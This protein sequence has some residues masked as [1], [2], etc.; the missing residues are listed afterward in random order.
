[1]GNTQVTNL[2][3]RIKK[4]IPVN[5]GFID[6][7]IEAVADVD[8]VTVVYGG[9]GTGK[10]AKPIIMIKEE[11][12]PK[13][14]QVVAFNNST[15]HWFEN[16][17][18]EEECV[19]VRTIDSI[20]VSFVGFENMVKVGDDIE[21]GVETLRRRVSSLFHVP[22]SNDP[23][24]LEEGNELFGLFDYVANK[25]GRDGIDTVIRVLSKVFPRYGAVL[26]VYIKCLE[27]KVRLRNSKKG[28]VF[29]CKPRYDFTL[30]RLEL[31]NSVLPRVKVGRE[32]CGAPRTLIV[33]EVQDLSPL[34]WA[35]LGKWLSSGEVEHFIVAGDF[36][37][38]IYRSLHHADLEIPRWLYH[39]AKVKHGWQ[40]IELT[41]SHRVPQPLDTL[42]I[43]FLNAFDKDPSPWRKWKG[44]R[45]KFG[46]LYIKPL[47]LALFEIARD[48]EQKEDLRWGRSSYAVLAPTNEVVL[49]VS[50][51][52]MTLGVLPHFLKGY[53]SAVA[54]YIEVVRRVVNGELGLG[55]LEALDD[56]SKN[57]IYGILRYVKLRARDYA[58]RSIVYHLS[59]EREVSDSDVMKYVVENEL[60][61][62][63]LVYAGNPNAPVFVD[64]VYTAKGLEFDRVYIAN[65]TLK[66]SRVPRD[67]WGARLFYVALT[68]SRGS[69]V[70]MTSNKEGDVEWFPVKAIAELAR[71][72]GVEVVVE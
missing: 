13:P 39:Q 1:M 7:F 58:V 12:V 34:M 32:D 53:P 29:D 41:H 21:R 70:I 48:V 25:A 35:I 16:R 23:Y 50:T 20:A 40:V 24:K 3:D 64:T 26:D 22:F 54:D 57:V 18:G 47:P 52:L 6:G 43:A 51:A 65:F 37:Q 69:V 72:A 56:D 66:N 62:K 4:L 42:A 33:D 14:A 10:T 11:L 68:R 60:N 8:K 45:D 5:R 31:L 30:A 55:A 2:F 46:I 9:P 49:R 38:L 61:P 44:N 17:L 67:K 15:A 27:G 36:D 28:E 63:K 19:S 59:S 71:R